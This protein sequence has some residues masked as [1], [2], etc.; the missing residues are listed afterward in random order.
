M[1]ASR[2]LLPPEEVSLKAVQ[3]PQWKIVD[4]KKLVRSFRFPDFKTALDL[5]DRIGA[6]AEK[7]GHHP[8]LR[9]GWGYVEVET[10]THDAGGITEQDFLLAAQIDR[11]D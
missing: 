8:D 9:L 6:I 11:L 10:S 3:L 5:V 1:G 7:Q 4:Q 2:T